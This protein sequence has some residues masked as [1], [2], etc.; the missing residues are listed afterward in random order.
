VFHK[1]G[2]VYAVIYLGFPLPKSS[3]DLP[4]KLERTTPLLFGLAPDEVYPATPVTSGAVGSYPTISPLPIARRYIFCGTF[5]SLTAAG[6]YPA[7][8][9]VEPGLSSPRRRRLRGTP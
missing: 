3:S 2:S 4:A 6:C 8:C 9:S 5:S 7:S 1:P